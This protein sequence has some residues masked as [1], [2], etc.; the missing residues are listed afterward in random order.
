[1]AK[2]AMGYSPSVLWRF[3]SNGEFDL[4]FSAKIVY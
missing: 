3:P 4:D 1:M 2:D